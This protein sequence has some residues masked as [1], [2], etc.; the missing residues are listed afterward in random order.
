MVFAVFGMLLASCTEDIVIDLEEGDPMIGVEASFSNELRSHE[1]I[2]SYTADFYNKDDI[3]YI[4]GATVFVTDG[5]DTMYYYEDA[6][7]KGHYFTEV[8]AGKK[9]TLYRLSM[10]QS[11]MAKWCIFLPRACCPI[12]WK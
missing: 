10:C 3:R 6:E 8:V 9:N 4:C 12:M 7:L 2:L 1:A 11:P 5:V